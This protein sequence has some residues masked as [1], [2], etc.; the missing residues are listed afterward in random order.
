MYLCRGKTSRVSKLSLLP[1]GK[2]AGESENTRNTDFLV[3]GQQVVKQ[4]ENEF[5][6]NERLAG[7]AAGEKEDGSSTRRAFGAVVA[8]DE[9]ELIIS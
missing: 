4:R 9:G 7:L 1:S 3:L 6:P 2:V 5:C 8:Y